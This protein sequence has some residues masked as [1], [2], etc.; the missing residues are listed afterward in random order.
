MT[1]QHP[2]SA[3]VTSRVHARFQRL[4]SVLTHIQ[5]GPRFN[6][7]QLAQKLGVARRTIFRDIQ[8]LR[9]I[10]FD[11]IFDEQAGGYRVLAGSALPDPFCW[12][13]DDV[14]LLVVAIQ[15]SLARAI[16]EFSHAAENVLTKIL[17][18]CNNVS[19][20][21][22]SLLLNACVLEDRPCPTLDNDVVLTIFSSIRSQKQIR[23]SFTKP[24]EGNWEQTKVAPYRIVASAAKWL[25]V[26]RS[27]LHRKTCTFDI[28]KIAKVELTEDSFC[29]PKEFR[30]PHAK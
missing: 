20:S 2:E 7:G 27:S 19:K 12:T 24:L 22:L 9:D 6:V 30:K 3:E 4:L 8:F 16:P 14:A 25:L 26:G 10:G 11:I 21:Q 15:F 18:A 1:E 13:T 28:S 23:V 5:S 17:S 29:V